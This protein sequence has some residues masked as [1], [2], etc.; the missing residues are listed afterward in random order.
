MKKED[1][2]SK[3]LEALV[4]TIDKFELSTAEILGILSLMQT[5]YVLSA[6]GLVK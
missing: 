5:G 6:G 1:V 3:A 2:H 4:D